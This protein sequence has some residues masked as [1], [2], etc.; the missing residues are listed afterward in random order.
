LLLVLFLLLLPLLPV[1]QKKLGHRHAYYWTSLFLYRW[2]LYDI[3]RSPE[4]QKRIVQEMSAAGLLQVGQQVFYFTYVQL[5]YQITKDCNGL[6]LNH[7]GLQGLGF[8]S[9][10]IARAWF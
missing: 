6:V 9:Q 1:L 3:A 2:A 5:I 4:I 7:K 10:R 8:G